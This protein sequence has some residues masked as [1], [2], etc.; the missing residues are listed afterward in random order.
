M[1]E[2]VLLPLSITRQANTHLDERKRREGMM[3]GREE[4]GGMTKGKRRNESEY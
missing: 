4:R 2:N 3:K 1:R